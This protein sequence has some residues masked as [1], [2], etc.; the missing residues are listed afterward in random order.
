[1]YIE[2]IKYSDTFVSYTLCTVLYSA[3]MDFFY[4]PMCSHAITGI[5]LHLVFMVQK[6]GLEQKYP[7]LPGTQHAGL[8]SCKDLPPSSSLSMPLRSRLLI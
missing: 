6:L 3:I 4:L 2:N 5:Y 1:M 7:E 8:Y